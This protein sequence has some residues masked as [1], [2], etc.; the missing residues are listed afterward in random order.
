MVDWVCGSD[1]EPD[2]HLVALV[3]EYCIRRERPLSGSSSSDYWVAE[4]LGK[5]KRQERFSMD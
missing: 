2:A 3:F 5:K 4:G 1:D